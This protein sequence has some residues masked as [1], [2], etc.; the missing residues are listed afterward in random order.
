M[1]EEDKWRTQE[2]RF[3]EGGE[4]EKKFVEV[5]DEF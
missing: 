5:E 3:G 1:T 4:E 2:S